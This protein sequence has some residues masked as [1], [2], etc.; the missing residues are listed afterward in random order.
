MIYPFVKPIRSGWKWGT[1]RTFLASNHQVRQ[2]EMGYGSTGQ[3]MSKPSS[4]HKIGLLLACGW[5][6]AL[7][8][9]ANFEMCHLRSLGRV[10]SFK[11]EACGNGG[12]GFDFL[13]FYHV[14]HAVVWSSGGVG[15]RSGE[16]VLTFLT[17]TSF[18]LRK[19]H[20]LRMLSYDH[21]GGWGWE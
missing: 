16:G 2:T 9:V 11:N 20:T 21:Q 1:N 4:P 18:T 15:V 19:M 14:A 10:A 3:T 7:G 6:G 12:I 17:S 13:S 8:R 5:Y